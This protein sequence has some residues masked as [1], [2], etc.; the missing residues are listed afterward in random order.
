MTK[1]CFSQVLLL[2]K[3]YRWASALELAYS[4]FFFWY[5]GR[6]CLISLSKLSGLTTCNNHPHFNQNVNCWLWNAGPEATLLSWMI[7]EQAVERWHAING[8]RKP[9]RFFLYQFQ[10][11]LEKF[12][13]ALA[14]GCYGNHMAVW[15]TTLVANSHTLQNN[16]KNDSS[17]NLSM[18][19]Y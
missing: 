6:Q 17:E 10:S 11:S 13:T 8:Y 7:N 3:W 2:R 9:L 14:S 1:T 5:S 19:S 15:P 18:L 4:F 16:K 12:D